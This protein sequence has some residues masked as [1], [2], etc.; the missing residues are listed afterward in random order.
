MTAGT[1][2]QTRN[3]LDVH[4][5]EPVYPEMAG[6]T[7]LSVNVTVEATL[8]EAGNVIDVHILRGHPLFHEAALNAVKQWELSQTLLHGTPVEVVTSIVLPFKNWHNGLLECRI[9]DAVPLALNPQH[10]TKTLLGSGAGIFPMLPDA[11]VNGA[12][13][14]P[15][16]VPGLNDALKQSSLAGELAKQMR[17]GYIC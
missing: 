5:V 15:K 3:F 13:A 17:L 1:H 7:R 8:D 14:Y 16:S 6:Q 2:V 9:S 11:S 12:R 10:R 4:R